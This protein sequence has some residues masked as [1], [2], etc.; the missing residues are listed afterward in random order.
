MERSYGF[1]VVVGKIKI[2]DNAI[3]GALQLVKRDV[4]ENEIVKTEMM[5]R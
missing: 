4:K 1:V 2:G 3:I 5:C